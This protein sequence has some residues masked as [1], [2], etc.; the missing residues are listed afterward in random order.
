MSGLGVALIGCSAIAAR[1]VTAL[2]GIPGIDLNWIHSRS[3]QRAETFAAQYG[4]PRYSDRIGDILADGATSVLLIVNEP[5]RH[6]E[7][8][9]PGLDAGKDILIEKPLC[10]DPDAAEAFQHHARNRDNLIGVMFPCRFNPV[11]L[12]MKKRVDQCPD[13]PKLVAIA[14]TKNRDRAY[15]EHGTGWRKAKGAVF[16]NQ[17]IHWL[18]VL[19]WF[20]GTPERVAALSSITRPYLDCPDVSGACIDY[21]GLVS[22]VV[23]GATFGKSVHGDRFTITMPTG[24]IDYQTILADMG[25]A[26]GWR[27]RLRALWEPGAPR[28]PGDLIHSPLVDFFHCVRTRGRPAVTLGDAVAA[29]RLAHTISNAVVT[30]AR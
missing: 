30:P 20:F 26:P 11:L 7:M 29:L 10:P 18:D 9:Y 28:P 22:A 4:I 25:P 1:Y 13:V 8:A 24:T 16:V 2:R 5:E 23:Q 19:N 6:L 14:F 21:P 12:E 17:G 3:P 27:G 15:Y